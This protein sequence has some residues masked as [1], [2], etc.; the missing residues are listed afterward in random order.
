MTQ[1]HFDHLLM[2]ENFK[3]FALLYLNDWYEKD[4]GF[5][6]ELSSS[7]STKEVRL[8]CLGEAAQYY[9]VLRDF[10]GVA[11][12]GLDQA[13]TMLEKV[14]QTVTI[15]NVCMVVPKLARDF[16]SAYSKENGKEKVSAAS[17]FLWIRC[18]SPV[19]IR[20]SNAFV[21]LQSARGGK[22]SKWDYA[23]YWKE[24]RKQFAKRKVRIRS[25]CAELV[26]IKEF[27]LAKDMTDRELKSIVESR[28]FHERVFDKCL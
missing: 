3:S 24:W 4:R 25:A 19:V 12:K 11:K 21:C 20:D 28:W 8:R 22:L 13:L 26:R 1:T 16:E 27:S 7:T 2:M 17:K 5:I 10:G 15:K 6:E 23:A 14:A 9:G 18:Q